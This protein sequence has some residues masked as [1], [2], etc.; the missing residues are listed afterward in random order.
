MIFET[1]SMYVKSKRSE[2]KK[3][4]FYK[5]KDQSVLI[6]WSSVRENSSV[7]GEEKKSMTNEHWTYLKT[8]AKTDFE[9]IYKDED[10]IL[11]YALIIN[12]DTICYKGE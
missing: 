8:S 2:F 5:T 12:N 6:T 1:I 7:R 4:Y 11:E 10:D 3:L 9:K